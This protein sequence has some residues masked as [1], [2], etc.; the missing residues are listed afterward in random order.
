[1]DEPVYGV[2]G[3]PTEASL[4]SS[5]TDSRVDRDSRKFY[6]TYSQATQA[7]SMRNEYTHIWDRPLPETSPIKHAQDI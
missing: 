3:R 4:S 6:Q 5:Y 7:E 1:M 2:Y